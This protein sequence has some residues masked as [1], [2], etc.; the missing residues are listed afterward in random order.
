MPG[1]RIMNDQEKAQKLIA[2]PNFISQLYA[3][4]DIHEVQ[5]LLKENG[6]T[7]SEED[8]KYYQMVLDSIPKEDSLKVTLPD[9][10]LNEQIREMGIFDEKG[11]A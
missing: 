6:V 4:R 11:D 8:L 7:M 2:D 3:C 10:E 1:R 9:E 5:E